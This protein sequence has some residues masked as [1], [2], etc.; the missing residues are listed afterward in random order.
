[1]ITAGFSTKN[2]NML[3]RVIRW[4]TKSRWSHCWIKYDH[5]IY[6][7]PI[8]VEADLTG[9]VEKPYN[10]YKNEI[11]DIMELVPPEGVDLNLGMPAL[12]MSLNEGYDYL[13]LV[14]RIWVLFMRKFGKSVKNPFG[15]KGRDCCVENQL[16]L[17]QAAGA[18]S[19]DIDTEVETPQSVYEKLIAAGWLEIVQEVAKR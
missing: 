9:I 3:S 5:P 4:F 2:K 14:G 15:D 10:L 13:S 12:G 16:R 1:M 19:Q 18:L 17:L 7:I 6:N 8:V 11:N